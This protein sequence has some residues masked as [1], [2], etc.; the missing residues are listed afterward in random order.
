MLVAGEFV[1]LTDTVPKGCNPVL[2]VDDRFIG[3]VKIAGDGSFDLNVGT[4]DLAPGRHVAVVA[5]TTP[6][7]PFLT[8]VFFV[9]AP[10][11]SSNIMLVALVSLLMLVALGWIGFQTLVGA[12]AIGG[13][14]AAGTAGAPQ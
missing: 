10:L 14:A 1:H 4:S 7:V 8:K 2:R 13:A 12:G 11:S 6:N 5:C 9:S 3:P